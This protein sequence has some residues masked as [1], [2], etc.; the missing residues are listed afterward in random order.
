[1]G[2]QSLSEAGGM[3]ACVVQA[4]PV[5]AS[6]DVGRAET[7]IRDS[8]EV[9]TSFAAGALPGGRTGGSKRVDGGG[10]KWQVSRP[11]GL[12]TSR[13]CISFGRNLH[14]VT[15]PEGVIDY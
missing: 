3:L 4:A 15:K 9:G 12:E 1:M 10:R 5:P 6:A 7:K 13:V 11:R 14:M 8:V 2:S